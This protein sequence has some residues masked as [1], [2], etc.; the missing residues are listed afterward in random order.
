[1]QLRTDL[2]AL[3]LLI[4]ITGCSASSTP[5]A[6]ATNLDSGA[7]DSDPGVTETDPGKPPVE[8]GTKCYLELVEQASNAK[9]AIED[10]TVLAT[11]TDRISHVYLWFRRLPAASQR[12]YVSLVLGTTPLAAGMYAGARAGAIETTLT[13]GRKFSTADVKKEGSF[14]LAIDNAG[15]ATETSDHYDVTGMLEATLIDAQDV[16]STL[17]LQC[18]MNRQ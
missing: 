1:M 12:M 3:T 10:C 6:D 13:D 15:R 4:A 18:W 14:Q 2:R 9:I 7:L 5:G 16:S 17:R 8:Y 11:S